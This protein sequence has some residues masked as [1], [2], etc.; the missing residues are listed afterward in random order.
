MYLTFKKFK[1]VNETQKKFRDIK[2]L[3]QD[4]DVQVNSEFLLLQN[5]LNMQINYL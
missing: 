4:F 3:E 2:E 1:R 5:E